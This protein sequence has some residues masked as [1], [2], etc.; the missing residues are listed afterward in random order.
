VSAKPLT[1]IMQVFAIVDRK[2]TMPWLSMV[3]LQRKVIIKWTSL[4]CQM[5]TGDWGFFQYWWSGL[6][7]RASRCWELYHIRITTGK[8]NDFTNFT[9][10][11]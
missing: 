3:H 1:D 2:E 6:A 9:I 11:F 5:K 7:G 8:E 4:P 10:Q